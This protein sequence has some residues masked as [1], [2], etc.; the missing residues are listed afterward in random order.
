MENK[1]WQEGTKKAM[2]NN[3]NKEIYL[4]KKHDCWY[5]CNDDNDICRAN[6]PV[7]FN[8]LFD[9]AEPKLNLEV[10]QEAMQSEARHSSQA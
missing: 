4:A 1:T 10:K 7:D 3:C 5:H 9:K 8:H 2:C 6:K